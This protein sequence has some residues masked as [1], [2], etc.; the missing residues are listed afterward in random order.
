MK[1]EIVE[2]HH[3]GFFLLINWS[4]VS[5]TASLHIYLECENVMKDF[6]EADIIRL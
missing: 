2:N 5:G 1:I 6:L 4:W 3:L